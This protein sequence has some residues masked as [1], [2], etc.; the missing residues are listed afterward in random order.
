[1]F[2]SLFQYPTVLQRH[3]EGPAADERQRFLIH[4][5]NEGA[6]HGTLLQI[7]R[8]LRMIAKYI[9]VRTGNTLDKHDLEIAAEKWARQ[10]QSRQRI[11]SRKWSRELFM[12]V[13]TAWLRF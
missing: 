13:G 8:E 2:E 6:A 5:A 9:D 12:R 10:Q 1:M 3:R 11:Q 7:A 4:R